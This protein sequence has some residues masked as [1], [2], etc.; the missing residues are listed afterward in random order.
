VPALLDLLLGGQR[1]THARYLTP[2]LLGLL[3]AV[4][5]LLATQTAELDG[6]TRRMWQAVAVALLAVSLFSSV[7]IVRS[8]SRWNKGNEKDLWQVVGAINAAGQPMVV[9]REPREL[10]IAHLVTLGQIL[11]AEVRIQLG[12]E[13]L[14]VTD[15]GHH[16]EE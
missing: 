3:L 4:A 7:T 10:E 1:S 8:E 12:G 2:S 13:A 14:A 9:M 15:A 11:D 16:L 5:H 6:R